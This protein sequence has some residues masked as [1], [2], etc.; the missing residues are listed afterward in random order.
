MR[1]HDIEYIAMRRTRGYA[2][3]EPLF[4]AGQAFA[5][6]QRKLATTGGTRENHAPWR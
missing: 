1:N 5:Q 6:V 2:S 4:H 3:I